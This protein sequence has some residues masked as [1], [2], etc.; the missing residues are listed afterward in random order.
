MRRC[1]QDFCVAFIHITI[2]RGHCLLSTAYELD[3]GITNCQSPPMCIHLSEN[4]FWLPPHSITMRPLWMSWVF[5]SFASSIFVI[6]C[7]EVLLLRQHKR[8]ISYFVQWWQWDFRSE[9]LVNGRFFFCRRRER[10]REWSTWSICLS[11]H[12]QRKAD[13]TD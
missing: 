5:H 7:G 13:E 12:T 4:A 10:E 8:I 1:L 6:E 11:L 3:S 2:S 9:W